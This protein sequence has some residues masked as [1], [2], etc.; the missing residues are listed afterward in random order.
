MQRGKHP[1][2]MKS[3]QITNT[4]NKVKY[5]TKTICTNKISDLGTIVKLVA[6]LWW[7]D[8]LEW[9]IKQWMDNKFLMVVVACFNVQDLSL[10]LRM[11]TIESPLRILN[12]CRWQ[13]LSN[14][15][16]SD[17]IQPKDHIYNCVIK[18]VGSRLFATS[19]G[20]C[21]DL[22]LMTKMSIDGYDS[23]W[24]VDIFPSTW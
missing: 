11:F 19:F 16:N 6:L 8:L 5:C 3:L 10:N 24:K 1:K 9:W 2:Q 4:L 7:N 22:S 21:S 20:D 23:W 15:Y 12:Y 14:R 13:P 17:E 18:P